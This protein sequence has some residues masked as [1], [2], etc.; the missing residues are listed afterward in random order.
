MRIIVVGNGLAGVISARTLRDLDKDVE[1]D[2]FASE[3]YHY[4]PRP[5]L[6]EFL[7]GNIPLGRVFAFPKQW[8]EEQKIRVHLE[9]SVTK[10][11][12]EAKHIETEEGKTEEYDAYISSLEPAP[13][14]TESYKDYF[15][16]RFQK[17]AEKTKGS[18][19]DFQTAKLYK[20]WG[21]VIKLAKDK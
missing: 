19:Q 18:I 16:E 15:K 13:D 10:I 1:I 4:Y 3:R 11:V 6:I 2:V 17:E 5:N 21:E 8:Y 14:D 20:A 9:N 7:D 12:P